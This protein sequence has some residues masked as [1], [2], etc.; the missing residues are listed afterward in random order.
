[1]KSR[2]GKANKYF[3]QNGLDMHL[4]SFLY[5]EN[6]SQNRSNFGTSLSTKNFIYFA[7]KTILKVTSSLKTI[8][9]FK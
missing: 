4:N 6:I 5:N 8:E 3:R 7:L 9:D 1:M 2:Q